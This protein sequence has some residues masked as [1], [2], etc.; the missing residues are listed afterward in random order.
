MRD[1]LLNKKNRRSL[2]IGKIENHIALLRRGFQSQNPF[3]F[4]VEMQL[5]EETESTLGF[6]PDPLP[7]DTDQ[8]VP[9]W[10]H[11]AAHLLLDFLMHYRLGGIETCKVY[12]KI[13]RDLANC[14]Y[15]FT[16]VECRNYH[17]LL[18]RL[19]KERKKTRRNGEP[20]K[21]FPYTEKMAKLIST[22]SRPKI[23][24]YGKAYWNEENLLTMLN[25]V[26]EYRLLCHDS[27]EL[28]R[29][30]SSDELWNEVASR[31][32]ASHK[33]HPSKC[34]QH[35]SLLCQQYKSVLTYNFQ[36]SKEV[37]GRSMGFQDI[38]ENILMPFT[39][40]DA[41]F[42]I[43]D[44]WWASE[45][46]GD[47]NRRETLDLLFTVREFWPGHPD[48]DW[49]MVRMM[50]DSSGYQRSAECC[51]NRF[52]KLYK[53]YQVA[54][55]HNKKCA[56][57][58]RRRPP[59]YFKLN[60]LFDCS[61]INEAVVTG[62]L[63]RQMIEVDEAEVLGVLV[64][65]LKEI[66]GKNCHSIPRLPLLLA[67]S[68]YLN[69][70]F[71]C[72]PEA[73][74]PHQIWRLLVQLHHTHEDAV[75]NNKQ[76]PD[77][78][79]LGDLWQNHSVPLKAYSLLAVPLPKWHSACAWRV[80]E[81]QL[82]TDSVISWEIVPRNLLL[83]ART[84]PKLASTELKL[85]GFKKTP[86]QCQNQWRYV[87]TAFKH[88]GYKQLAEQ[89]NLI[90]L[91][92]PCMLNPNLFYYYTVNNPNWKK[93]RKQHI[94][95]SLIKTSV[96]AERTEEHMLSYVQVNVP[97]LLDPKKCH[98]KI[99]TD[100][101]LERKEEEVV[102]ASSVEAAKTKTK[103][104]KTPL[105]QSV[106]EEHSPRESPQNMTK[107][108][109]NVGVPK[110]PEASMKETKNKNA[111]WN[112]LSYFRINVPQLLD[113]K[114]HHDKTSTD[115]KR[116]TKE[117]EVVSASSV[118]AAKIKT[119]Q[120]ETPLSQSVC[121]EHLP[122]ESPQNMIKDNQNVGVPKIPEVGMM[123]TKNKSAAGNMLSYVQ[124]NVPQPL[125][126]K[127]HHDKTSSDEKRELKEEVVSA[128]SV[129]AAKTKTTLTKT[130]LSQ[131][132]CDEHSPK[133]SQQMVKDNQN[134]GVPKIPEVG[135]MET[136]NKS[137][138]GNILSD[139]QV[140][141]P[142][143]LDPKKH[144]D[145]ISTDEKREM[146]EEG[147]VSTVVSAS[148]VGAT[149]TTRTETPLS[150]SV[151]EEHS[152]RESPHKMIKD[153]QN[154][155]V[156]KILEA[157]MME[158]KN[159]STTGNI[160]S[161]VQVNVPQLLAPKNCHDEISTDE[162]REMKEQE[163][164]SPSSVEA[165]KTTWTETP[166]SQSVCE[167]HS[168]RDSPQKMIKDNQNVG[169]PKV[170]ELSMMETKNKSVKI[171]TDEKRETKE[172]EVSSASS[173]SIKKKPNDLEFVRI[174]ATV[175]SLNKKPLKFKEVKKRPADEVQDMPT[176]STTVMITSQST[177]SEKSTY[178]LQCDSQEDKVQV[179]ILNVSKSKKA[180]LIECSTV[181]GVIPPRIIRLYYPPNC[182]LPAGLTHM[183]IP[184]ILVHSDTVNSIK[185]MKVSHSN[186]KY[187]IIKFE[188]N[189]S[190]SS[191]TPSHHSRINTESEDNEC[192]ETGLDN[193][194]N[195]SNI[196]SVGNNGLDGESR[197][198]EVI[199][200]LE[201]CK[202]E[203]IRLPNTL[204][205]SHQQ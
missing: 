170:P 191:F 189:S 160:F 107:D 190:S 81:L 94:Q 118:E 174:S 84:M 180:T 198:G 47:W 173:V 203:K 171:S 188:K 205:E 60:T 67:L 124:V 97:Q 62:S 164:V 115:E 101:K 78:I 37:A 10:S 186:D 143:L 52:Q 72:T 43:R 162:K 120:A 121:E 24:A 197:R 161:D 92:M 71:E 123:E 105:S 7:V 202:Q 127:K 200:L 109:Q 151:C 113:P 119:T 129:E 75:Q 141:A 36:I 55:E 76:L 41:D 110:I 155:G 18:R 40:H 99:S 73:F 183:Y 85:N 159:K 15:R 142:Q 144:H 65:G 117:E 199:K 134:V 104:T 178:I 51:Q 131:S 158:T 185:K 28:E 6:T 177:P 26:K 100:E 139:V 5:L 8:L 29:V 31:Q 148:S 106:C 89:I 152:P 33:L 179:M 9:Y 193:F 68:N 1:M 20:Y 59:F 90:Y 195:E 194:E 64:K 103:Q 165:V 154:V 176:L 3:P 45:G 32:N 168:P 2:E 187:P 135:M 132:V 77:E 19:Y 96:E 112:M 125:D 153:N 116:E 4:V 17:L 53:S 54:S 70:H 204:Q 182:K 196:P 46:G 25:T 136:K 11:R 114:K 80:E 156:P 140:N 98:D 14:G 82:L 122:R 167:E 35:F 108:N 172:E 13:S 27:A 12:E 87:V 86:L 74:P 102:S 128:S 111:L 30:L 63:G 50:M 163:V 38:I 88:G 49:E 34:L 83:V 146:K 147:V 79:N 69:N 130:P 21:T 133:E 22:R 91:L 149:K 192:E 138:T 145:K 61:E 42:D 169:V 137:A 66:K 44:E 48:V 150:Q 126:P 56:I 181:Q 166:L 201:E 23:A 57:R 39:C 16:G 157:S 93:K 95:S 184:R 58:T 175:S